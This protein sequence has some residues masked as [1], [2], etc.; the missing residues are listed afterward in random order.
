MNPAA[1]NLCPMKLR[2]SCWIPGNTVIAA[3]LLV[4]PLTACSNLRSKKGIGGLTAQQ[5]SDRGSASFDKDDYDGAIAEYTQAINLDP[6]MTRAYV[7]R[8]YAYY[9][10]GN[11]D[12][13][14]ADENKA[15][16]LDPRDGAAYID[17]GIVR[18][19]KGDAGATL[20]D[21]DKA[22]EV[23]P[24]IPEAYFNRGYRRFKNGDIEGALADM[25]KAIELNPRYSNAYLNRGA[26]RTTRG[27]WDGG[28]ADFEKVLEF[29]ANS[30]TA[31][32]DLAWIYATN[33]QAK[34]RSPK[35]V[36]YAEHAASLSKYQDPY[37]L[38][39]LAAAYADAG[40]F[41]KAIQ[42]QEKALTFSEYAQVEGDHARAR[43]RLYRAY[44]PYR[45]TFS[46]IA[47]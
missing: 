36:P 42:T 41:D 16:E 13:A 8:G 35:A 4:L 2:I 45:E 32:N 7:E 39:T 19:A 30:A 34:Y 44:K 27:D 46:R 10:K 24:T 43:L 40:E 3:L 29:N 11:Y 18:E 33:E 12:A 47:K 25:N 21:F 15:L 37:I 31:Y 5:Y 20:A 23:D 28:I 1:L 14:L 22:I 17:R 6:R 9:K 26:F 38:A